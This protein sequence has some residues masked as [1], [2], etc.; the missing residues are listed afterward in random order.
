MKLSIQNKHIKKIWTSAEGEKNQC[1]QPIKLQIEYYRV[2]VLKYY[3]SLHF[4]NSLRTHYW[5]HYENKN[6]LNIY[7]TL[8]CPQKVMNRIISKPRRTEACNKDIHVSLMAHKEL[9]A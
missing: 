6:T 9:D 4:E 5:I 1:G 3:I 8:K 2:L 7:W